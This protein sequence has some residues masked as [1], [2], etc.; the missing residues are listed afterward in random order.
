M[1]PYSSKEV[2]AH[3][4]FKLSNATR[5]FALSA[6]L[7][8][9]PWA[10]SGASVTYNLSSGSITTIQ[11]I[12]IST[13]QVS[14]CPIGGTNCLGGS[15]ALTGG[16][17]VVD[18]S[19][20]TLTS[21]ALSTTTG[22]VLQMGGFSGYSSVAFSNL[23]YASSAPTAMTG[24]AGIYN[25]GPVSGTVTTDLTF[26]LLAGGSQTV[27]GASFAAG[28]TGNLFIDQSGHANL[29]LTG[30]NLGVFCNPLTGNCV[31][32]KADFGAVG[33]IPEPGAA[34]AFAVGLALVVGTL[35]SRK[36]A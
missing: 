24:G 29:S 36:G 17:I 30:V 12:D 4:G 20:G 21:L 27:S 18:E 11:F 22:G 32:A 3:M 8:L 1:L 2:D 14:P 34:A 5:L 35:R 33:A 19:T 23:S 6:L 9:S 26:S 16:S 25:F 31:V 7:L 10:A 15:V 28:P 13:G